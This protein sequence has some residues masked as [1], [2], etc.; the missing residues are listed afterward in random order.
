GRPGPGCRPA[1]RI[2]PRP[3]GGERAWFRAGLRRAAALRLPG[4]RGRA[5]RPRRP[6]RPGRPHRARRRRAAAADLLAG[7]PRGGGARRQR[8][9]RR[10][11][12]RPDRGGPAGDGTARRHPR[13]RRRHLP[14][15]AEGGPGAAGPLPP[16]RP[17]HRLQ[18]DPRR[19]AADRPLLAA[20]GQHPGRPVGDA[21]TDRDDTRDGLPRTDRD[22]GANAHARVHRT[23]DRGYPD[24][25]A[26]HPAAGADCHGRGRGHPDRHPGAS[27]RLPHGPADAGA[28]PC[29]HPNPDSSSDPGAVAAAPGNR[30]RDRDDDRGGHGAPV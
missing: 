5:R 4:A 12:Q 11:G 1:S 14:R 9:P 2:L 17:G 28:H 16:D 10:P 26:L 27:S 18:P 13:P 21:G 20:A 15:A 23:S 24:P 25:P 19:R 7:H 6:A 22:G 29:R 3:A 30:D 8:R